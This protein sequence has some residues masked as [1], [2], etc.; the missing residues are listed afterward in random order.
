LL[1][2]SRIGGDAPNGKSN[3]DGCP[4]DR[5]SVI[6]IAAPILELSDAG[7]AQRADVRAGEGE[8]PLV[9]G[10][11]VRAQGQQ[12]EATRWTV[13]LELRQ[14]GAAAPDRFDHGRAVQ[15]DPGGRSGQWM[16]KA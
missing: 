5:L 7:D 12:F 3:E 11:I 15:V 16:Q 8:T 9:S 6:E 10:R 14:I 2:L 4:V 1:G 13:G